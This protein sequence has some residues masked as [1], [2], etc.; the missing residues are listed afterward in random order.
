MNADILGCGLG[1][2]TEGLGREAQLHPANTLGLDVYLKGASG[3]T[4]GVTDVVTGFGSTAGEITSSAHK[5][6]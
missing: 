5:Y 1:E 4:L 2:S 3:V 6:G